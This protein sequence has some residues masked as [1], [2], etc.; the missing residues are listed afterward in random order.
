MELR[1]N[2]QG[3]EP[4]S[5][6]VGQVGRLSNLDPSTSWSCAATPKEP[7]SARFPW[8]GRESNLPRPPPGTRSSPPQPSNHV[9]SQARQSPIAPRTT[10][11]TDSRPN[12][13]RMG[14]SLVGRVGIEPTTFGLKARCSAW[15][16]YRPWRQG[17]PP[18]SAGC[19]ATLK[20]MTAA[21]HTS[22]LEISPTYV[23]TS[24]QWQRLVSASRGCP[25]LGD[26][27]AS[28]WSWLAA[29]SATQMEPPPPGGF[30]V[31][32][33]GQPAVGSPVTRRTHGRYRSRHLT[34]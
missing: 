21:R 12:R 9:S 18:G 13:T 16:S 10:S 17:S 24:S 32:R 5:V 4:R 3:T 1:S 34:T 27:V 23:N 8:A 6:P 14:R 22:I 11:S 20:V 2:S 19:C 30:T 33:E 7:G 26:N 28:G 29:S 31:S 15:L 25:I